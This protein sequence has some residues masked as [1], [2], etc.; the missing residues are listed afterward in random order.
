MV[1]SKLSDLLFML[2]KKT[3]FTLIH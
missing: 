2:N 3:N 1:A